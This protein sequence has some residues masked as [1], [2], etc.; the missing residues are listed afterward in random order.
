M[1]KLATIW[2]ARARVRGFRP[3]VGTCSVCSARAGKRARTVFVQIGPWSRDDLICPRCL[4]IPRERAL[5][6]VL[7][8]AVPHWR[9]AR[10]HESSPSDRGASRVLRERCP[11]YDSSQFFPGTPS[12][13]F[14]DGVRCENLE[15]LSLESGSLD[16]LVTQDVMEH[17]LDPRAALLEMARV[18]RPGGVH[19]ATFP[20][21]PW[22]RCSRPRA[23][24]GDDGT[25]VALLP[26][27]YHCSPVGG[28]ALVTTDWGAD[29]FDRVEA[30][31]LECEVRHLFQDRRAGLD[32][33]HLDVFLFHR[34]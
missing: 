23:R 10:I 30:A 21:Q 1:G 13:A 6:T 7:E 5:V 15:A 31:G 14:V 24:R 16:V 33:E 9:T 32:G 26:P 11:G 17:V 28:R 29:L 2:G 4:S 8:D 20:W 34:R 19:I 3:G 27:E 12:G 22:L 18:L 25:V